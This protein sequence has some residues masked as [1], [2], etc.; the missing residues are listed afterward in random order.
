MNIRNIVTK[1]NLTVIGL[2]IFSITTFLCM[3]I[4]GV[5]IFAN[6]NNGLIYS[7]KSKNVKVNER[8]VLDN[9]F[10][11]YF[12]Y[13]LRYKNEKYKIP[14]WS[15]NSIKTNG[16]GFPYAVGKGL[17]DPPQLP[18]GVKEDTAV[19]AILGGSVA[20]QFFDYNY[21]TGH[22]KRLMKNKGFFS[23]K[24]IKFI[25]L[26]LAG[27]RQPQQLIVLSYFL[28]LGQK[29]D[30][31][32][33]LD[34]L[35]ELLH[36]SVNSQ[37]GVPIS[38]PNDDVWGNLGRYIEAENTSRIDQDSILARWHEGRRVTISFD[39]KRCKLGS[40]YFMHTLRMIYHH[41]RRTS[42]T[43]AKDAVK[44]KSYFS[45]RKGHNVVVPG[46][47][48]A[49][50]VREDILHKT[51]LLWKSTS[52]LMQAIITRF[53]GKYL[54]VLQ[55]SPHDPM[56]KRFEP[57]DKNYRQ[58]YFW[59]ID[60]LKRGYP[61]FRYH[62]K[63]LQKVGVKHV[64]SGRVFNKLDPAESPYRDDC[65]HLNVLGNKL[66]TEFIANALMN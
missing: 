28:S 23:N 3:E 24:K 4:G 56:S 11:P 40:C 37:K 20:Q 52:I 14:N 22:L 44:N 53:G 30:L 18:F 21:R 29:I 27:Y 25:N 8:T 48:A 32:I 46:D 33:N 34:G 50:P 26:A 38:F 15:P 65:C 1:L 58:R 49:K 42:L 61:I 2:C 9:V 6:D 45:S 64:D 5:I 10:H 13:V 16:D 47:W 31:A 19:V 63:Q 55:P 51:A 60:P 39:R 7:A 54:G 43:P 57:I 35:N 17:P 66:L 36:S 41:W 12:G 62:S 59:L